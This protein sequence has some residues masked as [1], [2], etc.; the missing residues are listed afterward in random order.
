M[1][2][3]SAMPLAPARAQKAAYLDYVR[4]AAEAG[5]EANPDVINR[6][7]DNVD[8]S[9]LWGYNSTAHPIYLADILG[10]LYQ[11]T[12]ER[13]YAE[14]AAQLLAEYGDLREA[15]P[16]DYYQHTS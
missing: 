7:K 9:V 4:Q 13:Q 16:D 2:A 6:W 1:I 10:F 15:Y 11:E 5:W 3:V 14:R 8:P 12:G